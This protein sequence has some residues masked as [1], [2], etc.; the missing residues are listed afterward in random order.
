MVLKSCFDG[1]TAGGQ[2][3]IELLGKSVH[4]T[5]QQP[6]VTRLVPELGRLWNS[7]NEPILNGYCVADWLRQSPNHQQNRTMALQALT[8]MLPRQAISITSC[9][10]SLTATMVSHHEGRIAGISMRRGNSH[11]KQTV[12]CSFA[13]LSLGYMIKF[14]TTCTL[15]D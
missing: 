15:V 2:I 5:L 13:E 6:C 12:T 1:S 9:G 10:T 3:E 7:H 4:E 14:I 11:D 8:A